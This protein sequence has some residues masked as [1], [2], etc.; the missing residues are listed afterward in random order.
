[1]QVTVEIPDDVAQKLAPEGKDPARAAL[2]AM[3]IEGYR[4]GALTAYQTRRLLGF[5]T[6]HELDG[7]LKAHNVTEHAYSLA[8]LEQDREALRQVNSEGR[9]GQ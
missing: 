3:A 9:T 4:S 6:G 5:V 8:D 1:M 2:E 7:F